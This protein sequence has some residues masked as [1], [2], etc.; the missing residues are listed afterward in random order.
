MITQ[1]PAQP[2]GDALQQFITGVV[3]QALVHVLEVIDID[4]DG[5]R[6]ALVA[7]GIGDAVTQVVDQQRAIRNTGQCVVRV[8]M[9]HFIQIMAR[10][11]EVHDDAVERHAG[12]GIRRIDNRAVRVYADTALAHPTRLTIG[13]LNT[14]LHAVA[15]ALRQLM[16]H[17]VPGG[18]EIL[19][20]NDGRPCAHG[21]IQEIRCRITAERAAPGADKTHAPVVI[22]LA[23]V[24]HHWHVR[25][26]GGQGALAITQARQPR[27][28]LGHIRGI[29]QRADHRA[30]L[31]AQRRAQHF[32]ASRLIRRIE[33]HKVGARHA[34]AD[35]H[36]AVFGQ[37]ML[38][39]VQ[40]EQVVVG[41]IQH[42]VLAERAAASL[43]TAH[44]EE[45]RIHR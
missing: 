32:V 2:F 40:R 37:P 22:H 23:L 43:K 11:G 28:A 1:G 15:V 18:D 34:A 27:C 14:V 30:G 44:V 36:F 19:A 12:G 38:G 3:P 8:P 26:H 17:I 45:R 16:L 20:R 7:F 31:V 25:D 35:Q 4:H 6:H 39:H 33:Q 5:G 13:Q 21:V 24:G 9:Y 29:P 41:D 42:V 10:L